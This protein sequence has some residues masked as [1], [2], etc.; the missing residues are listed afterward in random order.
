MNDYCK[1]I[2]SVI[3]M[4]RNAPKGAL[5]PKYANKALSRLDDAEMALE[6]A[7]R[8]EH[9]ANMPLPDNS[10]PGLCTCLPGTV[11]TKCPVHGSPF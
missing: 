5:D 1:A 7:F 6:R 11:D 4:V 9:P 10:P 8:P 3:Q 2:L